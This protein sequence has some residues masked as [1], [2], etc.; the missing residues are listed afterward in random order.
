EVHEIDRPAA[1]DIGEADPRW[2]EQVGVVE[3]RRTLHLDLG[4]ETAV[5]TVRPVADVAVA[6]AHQIRQA[7]AGHV[8]DEDLLPAPGERHARSAVVAV[9]HADPARRRE[10]VPALR[11]PQRVDLITADEQVGAT[12][13]REIDPPDRGIGRIDVRDTPESAE[14][15]PAL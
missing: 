14:R 11:R 5:A 8:R 3:L 1:I 7:I 10:A 15:G 4:A 6:Y 13:A 9:G 2:V 12:I